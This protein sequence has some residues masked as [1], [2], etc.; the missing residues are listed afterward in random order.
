MNIDE[1][2]NVWDFEA[3][4]KQQLPRHAIAYLSTGAGN[5]NVVEA[6]EQFWRK[7]Q[8]LPRVLAGS[9]VVDTS[10]DIF[11]SSL[12]HPIFL[13]P[14]ASHSAFHKNGENETVKGALR[15]GA[16][17]IYSTHSSV[18][19]QEIQTQPELNWWFQIYLHRNREIAYSLAELAIQKGARALVLTV[20]TPV[21]GYRDLDR[22]E[23]PQSG[24]RLTPGQPDSAYPNLQGLERFEDSLPRHRKV[25]DPVLDPK[26]DWSDVEKLLKRF[27]CPIILKGILHPGD[28]IK[29]FEFGVDAV[30]VSNHGGRNLDGSVVAAE[31]LPIIREAVGP[32]R[33]LLVDGGIRRGSDIFKAIALGA[34]SVL[35][36]RPYIWG[37]STFG[38]EGVSRVVE[39]LRTELEATMLLSGT[40]SLASINSSY[41]FLGK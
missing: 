8:I 13:A 15:S 21:A 25:I 41:L 9:E 32:H 20:D 24:P 37:L 22:R 38:H 40:K 36:G 1:M 10:F 27:G 33:K 29:A 4:A 39:I 3:L 28:A 16:P 7:L 30:I 2:V 31:M 14:V 23:F 12:S 35:V 5:G 19:L 6:N 18:S 26:V 11:G 17:L 34:N